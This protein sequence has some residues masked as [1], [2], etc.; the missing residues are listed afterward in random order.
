[1][2]VNKTEPISL[3]AINFLCN[4]FQCIEMQIKMLRASYIRKLNYSPRADNGGLVFVAFFQ[5]FNAIFL[6]SSYCLLPVCVFSL[7]LESVFKAEQ[8][9]II[10]RFSRFNVDCVRMK[11][12]EFLQKQ[13]KRKKTKQLKKI[14]CAHIH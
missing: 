4:H 14:V 12:K 3:N 11:K 6:S 13:Q 2:R 10:K 5:L 7:E 8:N 9:K 1:M